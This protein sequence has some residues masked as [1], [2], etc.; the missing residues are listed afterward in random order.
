MDI[1][2]CIYMYMYICMCV[3]YIKKILWVIMSFG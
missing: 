2:I 3:V 1:Y